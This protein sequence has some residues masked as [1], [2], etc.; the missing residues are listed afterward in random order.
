MGI[1]GIK[2]EVVEDLGR[3]LYPGRERVAEGAGEGPSTPAVPWT[4]VLSAGVSDHYLPGFSIFP[5]SRE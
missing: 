5:F 3:L 2:D 4:P 1:S